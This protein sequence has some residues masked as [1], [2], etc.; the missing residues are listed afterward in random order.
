MPH[1]LKNARKCEGIDPH[2]LKGT[3]TL[4]VWSPSGLPNLQSAIA[5]VKIQWFEDFFISL[6]RYS[7]VNVQNRLA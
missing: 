3:P 5:E 4:G 6:E 2:T 7:N 1:A